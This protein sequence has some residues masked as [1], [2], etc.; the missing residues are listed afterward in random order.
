MEVRLVDIDQR[1][2]VATDAGEELFEP[3][4]VLGPLGGLGLAQQ[5][6]DPLPAQLGGQQDSTDRVASHGKTQGGQDPLPQLLQR[7]AVARQSVV[8]RL[9]GG[10]DLDELLGLVGRKRGAGPPVRR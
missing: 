10:D 6:L 5:L 4:D 1:H 9:G 8:D 7:P 3:S 2:L